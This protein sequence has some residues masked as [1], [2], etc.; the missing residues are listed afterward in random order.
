[1]TKLC[2]SL[3]RTAVSSDRSELD[4]RVKGVG[5]SI[6]QCVAWVMMRGTKPTNMKDVQKWCCESFSEEELETEIPQL[7]LSLLEAHVR[8]LCGNL[9]KIDEQ[10]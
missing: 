4:L 7:K 2:E 10:L 8:R 1:M 6:F 3:T 9:D 5:S